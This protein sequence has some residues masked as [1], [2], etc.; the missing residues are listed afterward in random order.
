MEKNLILEAL[1][2]YQVDA[3]IK[4]SK[5]K[6]NKIDILNSLRALNNVITVSPIQLPALELKNTSEVEYTY[7]KIK[8][9][10]SQ[11]GGTDIDKI[12][13]DATSGTE[14]KPRIPGLLQFIIRHQS[15]KKI[16]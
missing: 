1:N 8:F 9:L 3:I 10:V 14:D 16:K 12:K 4:T 11:D 13:Q 2:I 15:L 5:V 7:I 6:I